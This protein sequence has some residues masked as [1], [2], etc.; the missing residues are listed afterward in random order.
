MPLVKSFEL[1]LSSNETTRSWNSEIVVSYSEASFLPR[2]LKQGELVPGTELSSD[3]ATRLT[4]V[5]RG[6]SEAVR[7]QERPLRCAAGPARP[8]EQARLMLG[9]RPSVLHLPVR[10]P[11]HRG[12]GRPEIRVVVRRTQ[13]LGQ[14]RAHNRQVGSGWEQGAGT[15]I[16]RRG[17]MYHYRAPSCERGIPRHGL[18]GALWRAP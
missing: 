8:E 14:P 1:R 12:A 9:P 15:M 4:L 18:D 10:G 6:R 13:V 11:R 17:E 3:D 7:C 2:S 5:D 16:D